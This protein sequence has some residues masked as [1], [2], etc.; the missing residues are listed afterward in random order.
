[1]SWTISKTRTFLKTLEIKITTEILNNLQQITIA[2]AVEDI[3]LLKLLQCRMT[4][5][6]I[7]H[8]GPSGL[9]PCNENHERTGPPGS[10]HRSTT[11]RGI[12]RER[13][14]SSLSSFD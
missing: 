1:M 9:I 12:Y 6:F 3:E 2:I 4:I 13:I 10:S 14:L 11:K 7:S 8:F 5:S